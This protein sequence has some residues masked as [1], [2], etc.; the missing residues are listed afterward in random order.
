M[1]EINQ[2]F[3]KKDTAMARNVKKIRT[4]KIS[5]PKLNLQ[6]GSQLTPGSS[7]RP[8]DLPWAYSLRTKT[9]ATW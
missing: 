9:A 4:L 2:I 5:R 3:L 6:E 7:R 1:F 8:T